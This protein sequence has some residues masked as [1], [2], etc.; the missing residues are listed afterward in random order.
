[1]SALPAAATRVPIV[2]ISYAADDPQWP[3][4]EVE[5]LASRLRAA[6]AHVHLDLWAQSRSGRHLSDAEWRD[7]MRSS[8]DAASHVL[9]LGSER[10]ARL[11]D[12]GSDEPSGRGVALESSLLEDWL[13]HRKQRNDGRIWLLLHEGSPKPRFLQAGLC[14]Q[15]RAPGERDELVNHLCRPGVASRLDAHRRR[16]HALIEEECLDLYYVALSGRQ[17]HEQ[18]VTRMRLP[19]ST[20]RHLRSDASEQPEITV[21]EHEDLLEVVQRDT[22]ALLLGEPGA[23][24]TF[25]LLKVMQRDLD[26]GREP[27]W[28]KLNHWLDGSCGFEDFVSAELP[29]LGASWR[30]HV[31]TGG[32]RLLLDGLNELPA[33]HAQ[34]QIERIVTWL[35]GNPNCPVLLSCRE[36]DLPAQAPAFLR[37]RL[38]IRPLRARQIRDFVEHYLVGGASCEAAVAHDVFWQIAGGEP[39]RSAWDRRPHGT[40]DAALDELVDGQGAAPA[41]WL[42]DAERKALEAIRADPAWQFPMAT[43]PYLL[44]MLLW[45]WS[46]EQREDRSAAGAPRRRIDVFGRY[47]R[48]RLCGELE[49][50]HGSVGDADAIQRALSEL[51]ARLQ[52]VAERTKRAREAGVL[53][54]RWDDVEP[55]ARPAY[56]VA[57]GARLLRR[58][59]E[60]LRFRHQLL[61]EFY[62]ARFLHDRLTEGGDA[63]VAR[64]WEPDQPLWD[65]AGWQQ[66]FLLLAE[67]QHTD[68]PTLLR[69]L[70]DIQPEV[71]GAVWAQTRKLNPALLTDA[72]ASEVVQ[73]LHA[74]MLPVQP[75]ADFP[76]REAAFGR[77]LGLML[78][79]DGRPLDRRPGVWGWYDKACGRAE[80]DIDWVRI[81]AGPFV[82]QGRPA[83]IER[84][85]L[86]SRH[87][88]TV[89]QFRAFVDDPGGWNDPRWW[90]GVPPHERPRPWQPDFDYANHPCI[91][92]SWWAAQAYCRW[93][94]ALRGQPVALPSEHQ[95]ERAAAG[96]EGSDY[97]WRGEWSNLKANAGATLGKTS[98][99]GLFG[100][101]CSMEG[102][103][104]L[105]GNVWE[106]TANRYGPDELGG[107]RT[108][109]VAVRE[110]FDR[111]ARRAVRG[112]SWIGHP[113]HCRSGFRLRSSPVVRFNYLGL[114][115]VCCPIP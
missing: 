66:P 35:R 102:V 50:T 110:R 10:Y 55:K 80:V 52:H 87:P 105:A 108:V 93:L 100:G 59:G 2:F 97:P 17:Q 65:R 71:A 1:M 89:S 101:G 77:G 30:E 84:D 39:F 18:P 76:R 12:R 46:E 74:Q 106:W 34:Q 81:P 4:S 63:L 72:L 85:F 88:I 78:M 115:V 90:H 20:L 79:P 64:V 43:N 56:T 51:A 15:Y 60:L 38:T 6:G 44:A 7:W 62:V 8:L 13:Y 95:W 94:A 103:H 19:Q 26:A 109:L 49:K 53:A 113:V 14:P 45:V 21:T 83:K 41:A 27:L 68:V 48:A 31:A 37:E 11:C 40:P 99:C 32:C 69:V 23:G 22:R 70:L 75:S 114:R 3:A 98:F 91:E 25:A 57:L 5:D 104:D 28:V 42:C 67:Y 61:H 111:N 112:G 36:E 58:E 107:W 96:T 82:Y 54:L 47:T 92:V 73:R 29:D 24:K 16:M 86:I 9:C 33:E